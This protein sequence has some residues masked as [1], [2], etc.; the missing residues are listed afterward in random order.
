[1]IHNNIFNYLVQIRMKEHIASGIAVANYLEKHPGVT[2]VLHPSLPS[3]PD[4]QLAVK[5]LKGQLLS[6]R[7]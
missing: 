3:H 4:H 7:N 5:Q 2:K 6:I 1:M